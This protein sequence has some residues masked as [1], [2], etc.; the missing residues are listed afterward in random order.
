M[1]TKIEQTIEELEAEV[2]AELEEANDADAPKANATKAEPMDKAKGEVQDT[3]K[4]VVD[5][6]QDSAPA[7]EVVKKAKEIK[8]DPAQKGE[9]K[10]DPIAKLKEDEKKDED[11][12]VKEIVSDNDAEVSADADNKVDT[13]SMKNGMIK[14]MKSMRKEDLSKLYNSFKATSLNKTKDEMYKEMTDGLANLSDEKIVE[15]NSSFNAKDAAKNEQDK[16]EKTEERLKSL[17]VKEH[18]DALLSNDANLSAD[19]K[20]KAAT[21]F[22]TAVKSKIRTE[23]K[24]LEDEYASELL[25]AQTDNRKSLSEKVDNYLNYV[26][27]EWM[28]EN[29]LALDRGLKGEIAEDFISGLKNLFEDHYIDVPNEKYDVLEAQADKI[30]K[31]EKKL[32]ETIQQVVEQKNSNSS[33]IKEKVMNDVTSDLTDTEIEKFQSLS[34]DVEYSNE[35]GYAE[36]LNT[37]KESYFPRQKIETKINNEVETGTAVQDITEGSPMAKYIDAIGKTAVTSGK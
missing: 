8:A 25:E 29:E 26:V 11:K 23:I 5:P 37:V 32:E 34:Q 21:I 4:P 14:A 18:V 12:E 3:G 35:E 31:L 15:L 20:S 27:E 6:E 28:K 24:R 22:E 2:I 36:K 1:A 16:D 7:K 30:T 13:S 9:G 33:L 10:G 17:D 19:F